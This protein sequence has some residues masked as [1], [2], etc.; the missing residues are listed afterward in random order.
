M[1]NIQNAFT[2]QEHLTVHERTQVNPLKILQIYVT[3]I[4]YCEFHEIPLTDLSGLQSYFHS[5]LF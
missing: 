4:C 1:R 5:V 2:L 3:G